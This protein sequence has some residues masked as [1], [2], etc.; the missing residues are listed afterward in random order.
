MRKAGTGRVV[1]IG[2]AGLFVTLVVG[3]LLQPRDWQT[4]PPAISG[5][6][7][8][9]DSDGQPTIYYLTE[10][11]WEKQ[12][13]SRR[14]SFTSPFARYVLIARHAET[15]EV[16][17][18]QRIRDIK[19]ALIGRGPSMLGPVPGGFW[20]WNEGLEVRDPKSL[21]ITLTGEQ[22]R[23]RN[24][25]LADNIPTEERFYK[26][27]EPHQALLF[28]GL[29]A[30][31]FQIDARTGKISPAQESLLEQVTWQKTAES[32]FTYVRPPGL[33]PFYQDL[34]G[35]VINSFM[36]RPER[37][38]TGGPRT[39][40]WYGLLTQS[41]RTALSKWSVRPSKPYGEV[42]RFL[43]RVAYQLDDR[44]QPEIDPARVEQLSEERFLEGGFLKRGARSIWDVPDPSSSL[45]LCRDKLGTD[46]PWVVV[47]IG[48]D[49]K[50]LWRQPTGIADLDQIADGGTHLIMAGYATKNEPTRLRKELLV[51]IDTRTG[52]RREFSVGATSSSI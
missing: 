29:D 22:I 8:K 21:A 24:P 44:N 2:L 36:T 19:N 20:L 51:W 31:F 6:L 49:G 45:V 39:G 40:Q 14:S 33:F 18:R 15:G 13:F 9:A 42:S 23:E 10:E 1:L 41:E 38:R 25:D 37:D 28:K 35:Y 32:G 12:Y 46:S 48:R 34:E 26:V 17:H 11:Q 30:R 27:S 16:L 4:Y 5:A 52:K 47:R 7:W 3:S 43:Y 50:S